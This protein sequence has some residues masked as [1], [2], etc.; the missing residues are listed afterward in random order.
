MRYVLIDLATVKG[1]RPAGY[2]SRGQATQFYSALA[3][4]EAL[5]ES[6]PPPTED[7][8]VDPEGEELAKEVAER[9]RERERE[10][11]SRRR[12]SGGGGMP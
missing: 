4:E 9:E 5:N 8:K 6:P 12:V 11:K 1:D 2:W 3:A 10:R 7:A